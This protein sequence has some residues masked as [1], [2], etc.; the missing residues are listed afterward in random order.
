MTKAHVDFTGWEFEDVY[1]RQVPP[2]AFLSSEPAKPITVR[3]AGRERTVVA[4][5]WNHAI[6]RAYSEAAVESGGELGR[7]ELCG[8][9]LRYSA[10]FSDAEGR[11]HVVGQECANRVE[12]NCADREE[13]VIVASM[14]EAKEINTKNGLRW[15]VDLREPSGFRVI[16]YA[17]RP[18]YCSTWT[19]KGPRIR[20][21]QTWGN[22]RVT[23]WANTEAELY[24]NVREF[25]L[26]LRSK[27][28]N[29][30]QVVKPRRY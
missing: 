6:F 10:I 23:L 26:W 2:G 4:L 22:P 19:P 9:H 8:A 5:N 29:L 3:V 18:S 16:P 12:A 14:K 30:A 25:R 27:N 21:R 13:W 15:K 28:L 24:D 7:C 11:I 17:E 20:G 1:D